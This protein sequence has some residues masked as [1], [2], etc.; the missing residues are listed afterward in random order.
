MDDWIAGVVIACCIEGWVV[1][2]LFVCSDWL[3]GLLDGCCLWLDR[4]S[5]GWIDR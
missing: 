5:S 1:G 4:W 2:L 3:A